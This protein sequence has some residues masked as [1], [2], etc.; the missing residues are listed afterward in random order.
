MDS[1]GRVINVSS[2][3]SM[4]AYP[5]CIAYAMSKAAVNSFTVSLAAQLGP[6]GIT[7]NAVAPGATVTDFIESHL[8]NPAYVE[9][10][11]GKTALGRLGQPDDIA[12]AVTF[13]ASPVSGWITGQII[14]ASGGMHL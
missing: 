2:M 10:L 12:S 11:V 3:V 4:S 9:A 8:Q 13:L 6:R 14:A 5:G 1:G 7:V